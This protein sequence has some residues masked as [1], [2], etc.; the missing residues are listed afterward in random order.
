LMVFSVVGFAQKVSVVGNP[1]SS[2]NAIIGN[3]RYHVSESIYTNQE[4][5]YPNFISSSTA[6]QKVGFV[7]DA[8]GDPLVVSNFRIWM[9]NISSN[10]T[11]FPFQSAYTTTGY[12]LVFSGTVNTADTVDGN[13]LEI[14]LNTPFQRGFGS[15]L[16]VLIERL[17]GAIHSGF[18][19][20]TA[21]G[22]SSDRLAKSSREYNDAT[23]P[24]SGTTTLRP[25]KLRPA[26]QLV[27]VFTN[28]AGIKEIIHPTV[29]CFDTNISIGVNL[30]ND[31]VTTIPAGGAQVTLKIGGANSYTA[32]L[33][34]SSAINSG[35]N[36][37]ITF[38]GIS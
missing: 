32:T 21:N 26:I 20:A 23:L 15:N 9:K 5:G 36:E 11:V 1:S 2:S 8:L 24:V 12:T 17:D 30:T 3:S 29:S 38:T 4:L 19:F 16:Q 13:I 27:H 28:D 6:I 7:V 34:N 37:I 35:A 22:N 31:G 33:T 10:E 14:T 18:Q 25:T